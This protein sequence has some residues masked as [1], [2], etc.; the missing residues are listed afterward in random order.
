MSLKYI[1]LDAPGG[2]APIIFPRSFY[3]SYVAGLFSGMTVLGA[4]FV[5]IGEDVSGGVRCYGTSSSLRIDSRGDVDTKL[6]NDVGAASAP[7]LPGDV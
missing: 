6:V 4:G 1:V 2:E 7:I 3:H 5:E